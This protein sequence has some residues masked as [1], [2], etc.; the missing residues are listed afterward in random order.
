MTDLQNL[1]DEII[2]YYLKTSPVKATA[3]GI[4]DYDHLLDCADSAFRGQR[5]AELRKFLTRL[6]QAASHNELSVDDKL[7]CQILYGHLR[8]EIYVE[9][10][11][12]RWE[13]DPSMPLQL[14]LYG[15]YLLVLRDFAPIEERIRSLTARL[16][17][18]PQL[19]SE[20]V[21]NYRRER[22][23]PVVWAEMGEEMAIAAITFFSQTIPSI[24]NM[25]PAL[26][27]PLL[28]AS[29]SAAIACAGYLAFLKE[30]LTNRSRGT[31]A[32]GAE[33]FDLLLKNLHGLSCTGNEL[34]QIGSDVIDD[35]LS[36]MNKL[37]SRINPKG[38]L[39]QVIATLKGS[40]CQDS[41]LT[42]Y[43]QTLVARARQHVIDNDL[44]TIPRDDKLD[45]VDT[46]L[47]AR[48]TYP[49]AAY[50]PAAPFASDQ[51]GFFWVTPIEAGSSPEAE[52]EQRKG[53]NQYQA[54]LVALHEAYPGHHLQIYYANRVTSKVRKLFD[55]PIFIEGW[56]LYCEQMM[57]E[58][59]YYP[60][61]ES[62][63]MQL[64]GQL[65]RACRVVIDVGLHNGRM[66]FS[67]AV[68]M[69]VDTAAIGRGSAVAEVKRYCQSPTQP[70]SYIIGK[71]EILK[72]RE[73]YRKMMKDQFQLKNFHDRLLSYGSIPVSM[74]RRMMLEQK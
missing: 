45:F 56:A 55:T 65:W 53:H 42:G 73:E 22:D 7:D 38:T 33:G 10:N 4:H 74:V 40:T 27:E 50:L 20:A 46:P 14:A 6:S 48:S 58:T 54:M 3:A 16:Q 66:T 52:L 30:E 15:C 63:L 34:Q 41:V 2:N 59:G 37:A 17:A 1:F 44:V 18:V 12:R 29:E 9:E 72:L 49:F 26:K 35:T 61:D 21:G 39:E 71:I 70:M 28:K 19:L 5:V 36:Q 69:L 24:G 60:D 64:N 25:A 67:D 43:Y 31:Y 8:A 51:Q 47:F 57:N 32:L 11:Y 13:R 68:S 23:V 62:R